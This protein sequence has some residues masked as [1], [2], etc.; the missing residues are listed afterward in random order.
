M[1]SNN[2]AAVFDHECLTEAQAAKHELLCKVLPVG[3]V[4]CALGAS[5]GIIFVVLALF[6]QGGWQGLDSDWQSVWEFG[7][8][9]IVV[10]GAV[11]WGVGSVEF[12]LSRDLVRLDLA[13]VAKLT[14]I[15]ERDPRVA[16]RV[17]AWLGAGRTL[18][19]RDLRAAERFDAAQQALEEAQA[20]QKAKDD[21]VAALASAAAAHTDLQDKAM[22]EKHA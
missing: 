6:M 9:G 11:F 2:S 8:V 1:K 5:V 7:V 13:Q 10:S 19:V 15:V 22:E 14:A 20:K 4:V 17:R 12:A 18:R 16:E 3:G 21:A